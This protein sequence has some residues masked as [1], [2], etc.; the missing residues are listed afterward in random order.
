MPDTA[1]L[2]LPL[3]ALQQ[4]SLEHLISGL[5]EDDRPPPTVDAAVPCQ[6]TGYTEWISA[7]QPALTIGWDWELHTGPEHWALRRIGEPRSNVCLSWQ[8]GGACDWHHSDALL[9]GFVDGYNWQNETLLN[10][11]SRYQA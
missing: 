7:G 4:R 5:D 6:L 9:S 10:I 8:T 1:D 2:R 11:Q 3:Q